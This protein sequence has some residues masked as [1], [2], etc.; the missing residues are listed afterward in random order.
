VRSPKR[1]IG[2]TLWAAAAAGFWSRAMRWLQPPRQS[3]TVPP[4]P[5]V[6]RD[7]R[8]TGTERRAAD[9]REH[10]RREGVNGMAAAIGAAT[11]RRSGEDRRQPTN[12]READRRQSVPV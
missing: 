4:T 9:R 11:E 12:R 6:P 1:L 8:R 7:E 3:V 10:D 5:S 2:F